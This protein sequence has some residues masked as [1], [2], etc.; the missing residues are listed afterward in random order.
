MSGTEDVVRCADGDACEFGSDA[1]LTAVN[2]F[3]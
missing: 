1:F 3:F 2:D